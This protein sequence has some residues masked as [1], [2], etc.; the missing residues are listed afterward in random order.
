MRPKI[1]TVI[2]RGAGRESGGG[3][4]PSGHIVPKNFYP[5]QVSYCAVVAFE[6]SSQIRNRAG[7][8]NI[9]AR[10]IIVGDETG[11]VRGR[12]ASIAETQLSRS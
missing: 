6:Q 11:L 8:G 9:E 12:L 7:I 1:L 3:H 2:G 10:P 4:G 5:V